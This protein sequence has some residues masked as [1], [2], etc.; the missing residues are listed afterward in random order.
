M[1][2]A[3]SVGVGVVGRLVENVSLVD[4]DANDP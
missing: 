1:P 2:G 3:G 4:A